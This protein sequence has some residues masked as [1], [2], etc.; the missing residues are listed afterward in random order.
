MII[1]IMEKI[2]NIK[3]GKVFGRYQKYLKKLTLKKSS[4]KNI[5]NIQSIQN[6]KN[7]F[8]NYS[9]NFEASTFYVTR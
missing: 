5:H 8:L 2:I 7:N 3:R 6:K 4:M 9:L 1:M